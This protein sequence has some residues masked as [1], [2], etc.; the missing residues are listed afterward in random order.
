MIKSVS[1]K[2][3][4]PGLET[5]EIVDLREL[6]APEPMEKVLLASSKLG[7]GQFFLAHLPHV[8]MPLF[9][10]LELRGLRWWVHEEAD[11]S[12][13]ILIRKET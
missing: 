9:P 5:L 12:A 8:P 2:F 11:Q 7:D 4:V 13:L 1:H 6:E 3:P 10:Q